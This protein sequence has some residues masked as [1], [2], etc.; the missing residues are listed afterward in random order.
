MSRGIYEGQ[1]AFLSGDRGSGISGHKYS[2]GVYVD[3]HNVQVQNFYSAVHPQANP[4]DALVGVSSLPNTGSVTGTGGTASAVALMGLGQGCWV[5]GTD[6]P[7]NLDEIKGVFKNKYALA[8]VAVAVGAGGYVLYRRSKVSAGTGSTT[9][10]ASTA[11]GVTG[12]G[13]GTADTTGNDVATWLGSYSQNLQNTLNQQL[14]AYGTTLNDALKGITPTTPAPTTTDVGPYPGTPRPTGTTAYV[15]KAG[16]GWA[17]VLSA[18]GFS[19]TSDATA[20]EQ[21]NVPTRDDCGRERKGSEEQRCRIR[22]PDVR[23]RHGAR[24]PDLQSREAV[25]AP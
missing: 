6:V 19:G 18:L 15:T 10:D 16:Q 3:G 7:F 25:G 12:V 1:P 21:W 23:R 2:G 24:G 5:W 13:S 20:L 8:G 4:M 17:D 22:L 9:P 11:T 14:S